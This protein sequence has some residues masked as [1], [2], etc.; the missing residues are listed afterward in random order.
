MEIH[1]MEIQ[2]NQIKSINSRWKSN[3]I[4]FNSLIR[5]GDSRDGNSI[6]FNLIYFF[7]ST[8][9]LLYLRKEMASPNTWYIYM[10]DSGA[11]RQPLRSP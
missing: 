1:E 5:D 4:Q 9:R 10:Y 3:S 7:T 8:L 6:Q 2:F 11:G